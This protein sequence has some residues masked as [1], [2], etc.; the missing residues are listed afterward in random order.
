MASGES[1]NDWSADAQSEEALNTAFLQEIGLY[2][3]N[4]KDQSE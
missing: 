4:Y 1:T 2:F 3:V